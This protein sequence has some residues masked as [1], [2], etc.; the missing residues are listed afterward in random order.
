MNKNYDV[1]NKG[2][3][4]CNKFDICIGRQYV[5]IRTCFIEYKMRL[6]L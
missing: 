3:I 2:G 1:T 5:I 4:Y 6:D